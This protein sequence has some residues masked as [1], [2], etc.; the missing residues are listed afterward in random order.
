ML[1]NWNANLNVL[2]IGF[3]T[4]CTALYIFERNQE[5]FTM[6]N[7][8]QKWSV[9]EFLLLYFFFLFMLFFV[10]VLGLI[11]FFFKRLLT[12]YVLVILKNNR[13][14]LEGRDSGNIYFHNKYLTKG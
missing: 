10:T 2:K 9:F 3:V 11:L 13:V 6:E 7:K 8:I 5:L 12:I 4:L 1:L 14:F